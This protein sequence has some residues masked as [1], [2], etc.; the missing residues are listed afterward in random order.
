MQLASMCE[1]AQFFLSKRCAE[2]ARNFSRRF[3]EEPTG[4]APNCSPSPCPSPK[5]GQPCRLGPEKPSRAREAKPGQRSQAR[6]E[7]PS[8]ARDVQGKPSRDRRAN[9][10]RERGVAR[11]GC[12][13]VWSIHQPARRHLVL[14]QRGA[15]HYV[16]NTPFRGVV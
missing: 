7:K 9:A 16:S 15:G 11:V 4:K 14:T 8:Q 5:L 1:N 3:H 2:M 12:V 6:P 13:C 10:R